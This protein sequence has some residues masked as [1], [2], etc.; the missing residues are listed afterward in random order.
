MWPAIRRGPV[1]GDLICGIQQSW[2]LLSG[3]SRSE[4]QTLQTPNLENLLVELLQLLLVLG[5]AGVGLWTCTRATKLNIR[6]LVIEE[7][8]DL[9]LALEIGNVTKGR[10]HGMGNIGYIL[11]INHCTR[12]V[13]YRSAQHCN[14]QKNWLNARRERDECLHWKLT[15]S[16]VCA[17]IWDARWGREWSA[18]SHPDAAA[19]VRVGT[20]ERVRSESSVPTGRHAYLLLEDLERLEVIA[21]DAQLLLELYH[22][23][24]SRARCTGGAVHWRRGALEARSRNCL[25]QRPTSTSTRAPIRSH[26][27]LR[28]SRASGERARERT[29]QG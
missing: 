6:T 22:L 24:A 29:L 28:L 27:S 3:G 10:M 23:T 5:S 11:E 17:R 15:R 18:R 4:K 14:K 26:W 8:N 13:Q 20:G 25:S 19:P 21:H 7:M 1:Y 12:G 16:G 9:Q 2:D